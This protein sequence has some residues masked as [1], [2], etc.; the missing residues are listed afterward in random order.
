MF[1]GTTLKPEHKA[2]TPAQVSPVE[3]VTAPANHGAPKPTQPA[4]KVNLP[5][6]GKRATE[7]YRFQME[8]AD[9]QIENGLSDCFLFLLSQTEAYKQLSEDLEVQE[10][11]EGKVHGNYFAHFTKLINGSM[12]SLREGLQGGTNLKRLEYMLSKLVM[13][14]KRSWFESSEIEAAVAS[15]THGQVAAMLIDELKDHELVSD[16]DCSLSAFLLKL[17]F[18]D[19][20]DHNIIPNGESNKLDAVRG[21]KAQLVNLLKDKPFETH[22]ARLL[23][24]FALGDYLDSIEIDEIGEKLVIS[25]R[26]II[27]RDLKSISPSE[28]C[29]RVG[30]VGHLRKSKFKRFDFTNNITVGVISLEMEVIMNYNKRALTFVMPTSNRITSSN[31]SILAGMDIEGVTDDKALLSKHHFKT[32]EVSATIQLLENKVQFASADFDWV[33]LAINIY[34]KGINWA[35][36]EDEQLKDSEGQSNKSIFVAFDTKFSDLR[37]ALKIPIFTSKLNTKFVPDSKEESYSDCFVSENPNATVKDLL[38]FLNKRARAPSEG[39]ALGNY[40]TNHISFLR[41]DESGEYSPKSDA[42]KLSDILKAIRSEEFPPEAAKSPQKCSQLLPFFCRFSKDIKTDNEQMPSAA[43]SI[44]KSNMSNFYN[45]IFDMSFDETKHTEAHVDFFHRETSAFWLPTILVLDVSTISSALVDPKQGLRFSV[46]E[47]AIG[48]LGTAINTEYLPIGLV[49]C[50]KADKNFYYPI[51]VDWKKREA[52]GY[53]ETKKTFFLRMLSD[54]FV[55][56]VIL[57]RK[58]HESQ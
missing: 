12:E 42:E 55:H 15:F 54:G 36:A 14:V 53:L 21:K 29:D 3:K 51:A 28:Y 8:T 49:C 35:L 44:V 58:V 27:L 17:L 32:P 30:Q 4:T 48:K 57:E 19:G 2:H 25:T 47:Q 33:M 56:F 50:T 38:E 24:R 43:A 1:T 31:Q 10:I 40:T 16:E 11:L 5:Y 45:Y 41:M 23:T 18:K 26:S 13:S 7:Q 6:I 39:D 22:F 20:V 52:T 46:F 37:T 34:F 9:F